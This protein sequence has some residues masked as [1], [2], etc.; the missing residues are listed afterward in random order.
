MINHGK[1]YSSDTPNEIEITGSG[2]FVA[3]N[4]EPYTTTV[5]GYEVTGY[6]Y[7]CIEYTKDE[8]LLQQTNKVTELEQELSAAKIL[9]G[10]D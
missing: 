3:S 6:Q 5:D 4:I 2:V 8:F 9:L 1:V 10:V 7:D